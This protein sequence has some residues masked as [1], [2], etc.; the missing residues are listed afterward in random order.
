MD[1]FGAAAGCLALDAALRALAL[2]FRAAPAAVVRAAVAPFGFFAVRV[3]VLP[4][5]FRFALAAPLAASLV[6]ELFLALILGL[7]FFATVHL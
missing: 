2:G 6:R 3:R 7:V 5:G 1:V 4:D